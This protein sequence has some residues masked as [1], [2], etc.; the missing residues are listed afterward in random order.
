MTDMEK[1]LPGTLRYAVQVLAELSD[2]DFAAA[3]RRGKV[4]LVAKVI[5]HKSRALIKCAREA[6]CRSGLS[7]P[8][9]RNEG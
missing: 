4:A 2:Y 7:C 1:P 9:C 3:I 5:G 8:Y 6:R